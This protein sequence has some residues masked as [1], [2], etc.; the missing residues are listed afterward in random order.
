MFYGGQN[1]KPTG[2]AALENCGGNMWPE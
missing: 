1:T 2:E